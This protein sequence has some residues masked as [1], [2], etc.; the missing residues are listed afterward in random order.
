L[1]DWRVGTETFR[2]C[3]FHGEFTGRK[4]PEPAQRFGGIG[5]EE[6]DGNQ[7]NPRTVIGAPMTTKSKT[8][9]FRTIRIGVTH[10]SE[11]GLILLDQMCTVDK[12]LVGSVDR[13]AHCHVEQASGSLRRVR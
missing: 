4:L 12:Q 3:C 13:D 8:A 5:C 10:D 1:A 11:K 7:A 9:P 2:S 6:F